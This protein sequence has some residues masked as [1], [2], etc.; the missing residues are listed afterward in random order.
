MRKILSTLLVVLA[1]IFGFLMGFLFGLLGVAIVFAITLI[2]TMIYQMIVKNKEQKQYS[3]I[4]R[5]IEEYKALIE[6]EIDKA[7]ETNSKLVQ[8]IINSTICIDELMD[9]LHSYLDIK[10]Y[11][12][13]S[14]QE[15]DG[16]L[17][18]IVID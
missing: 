9:K 16:F 14:S 6:S 8:I 2:S 4:G 18:K 15:N 12:Y 5:E 11:N 7:Y 1:C 13:T 17:I 10:N 3:D